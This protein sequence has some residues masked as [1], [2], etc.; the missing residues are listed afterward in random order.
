MIL[1]LS[2]VLGKNVKLERIQYWKVFIYIPQEFCQKRW[3]SPINEKVTKSVRKI[4]VYILLLQ[5][6]HIKMWLDAE[7]KEG[8]FHNGTLMH[9]EFSAARQELAPYT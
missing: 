5:R 4:I 7:D 9:V 3:L 1:E 6:T 8:D 2:L